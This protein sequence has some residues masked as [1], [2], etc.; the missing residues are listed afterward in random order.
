[1]NQ[2]HY[3]VKEIS[4]SEEE[5]AQFYQSQIIDNLKLYTNE[6][7]LI[8]HKD[9]I[10]DKYRYDGETFQKVKPI[11]FKNTRVLKPLDDIQMCA[12]DALFNKDI[13]VVCLIGKS[14]TGK[15]RTSIS[16]GLEL[17]KQGVY[18]KIILVRHAEESGKSIGFLKGDKDTKMLDGWAGCFYDNLDGNKY[19]FED[20]MKKEMVQIESLSLLKGRNYKNSFLIFDESEDAFPEQIELVGTRINDDCKLVYVGDTEQVSN[21]KYK[22]N[23]GLL[24]LLN[25][26]KGKEWF[27]GIELQTNARGTVAEFFSTEFKE[28]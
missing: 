24:K 22:K 7:L 25:K 9:N 21:I 1:M 3:G 23:S 2:N 27:A 8:K 5:L 4:L 17:L 11:K 12:Y 10:I 19:E 14:G 6:Y 20:F 18:D 13:K 26:A 15:T 28:D 16:V